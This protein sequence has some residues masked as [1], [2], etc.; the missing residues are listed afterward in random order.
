MFISFVKKF[1]AVLTALLTFASGAATMPERRTEPVFSGTFLQ[2]WLGVQW[3]D[4]DWKAEIN[5]MKQDGIEYLIIQNVADKTQKTAGGKWTVYFDTEVKQLKNAK[6]EANIVEAALR[7]CKGTGI[8]VIIGLAIFE[9]FWYRGA[10]TSQYNEC[11]S[12]SA[13]LA[14]E[15]YEKYGEEYK[16]TLFAFY[17]TPEFSN[18]IFDSASALRLSKGLNVLLD[19]MSES[20]GNLPLVMSP[21]VTDYFTFGKID[22]FAFWSKIF[23]YSKFRD[24]DIVAPQDAVGAGFVKTSELERNW[25]MFRTL[26][27]SCDAKL[28][29][30][31]NCESFS[32]AR[33][34]SAISGI[35]V[36]NET[37][38][39]VSVPACM[40]RFALQ[41]D[42]ASRYCDNIITFS[43]NHYLSK[44]Q[45]SSQFIEAYRTYVKNGFTP[46]TN[47][48]QKAKN[49]SKK[50]S[51]N[52]IVLTWDE[53]IDDI[54]IAY[55][56]ITKNGKFLSRIECIYNETELSFTD[57]GGKASDVY[58]ITACDTSGNFSASVTAK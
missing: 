31:A 5:E 19:E 18:I 16:D 44:N 50:Q 25:K 35:A 46:E 40:D 32:I 24:G 56:K 26:V 52:G 58:V 7:A 38:N 48:P 41:L 1:F 20:C 12:I 11:C 10:L 3:S 30:W 28:K 36:P 6:K 22:M 9:D 29:L 49:F 42:I 39:K 53:A 4:E 17:F 8:K 55:Y 45:I 34:K 57:E 33:A 43:Y 14:K 51:E 23:A 13:A 54:G 27:D 15:I 37:E 21:Y 2:P 47:A